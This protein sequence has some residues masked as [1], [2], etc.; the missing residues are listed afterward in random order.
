MNETSTYQKNAVQRKQ[1]HYSPNLVNTAINAIDH[2]RLVTIEHDSYTKGISIRDLEPMA[3]VYKDGRRSLVGWCR[4]R[5]DYRSFAL[6][7]VIT[8][9]IRQEEFNRRCD[10]KIEDF[11]D[12]PNVV[13]HEEHEA[14]G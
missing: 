11:Q 8:I 6:D 9:K 1:L 10:F 4:L 13:Y 3:I 7:K 5:N 12:D 2:R 14:E